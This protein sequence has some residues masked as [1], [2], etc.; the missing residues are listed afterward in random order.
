MLNIFLLIERFISLHFIGDVYK[1]CYFP[2]F[3]LY[4]SS[5]SNYQF[6]APNDLN[7]PRLDTLKDQSEPASFAFSPITFFQLFSHRAY[8][9][10]VFVIRQ[11]G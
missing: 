9:A 3:S 6:Y 8:R 10:F 7:F 1:Y 11:R 5:A 4:F 2:K